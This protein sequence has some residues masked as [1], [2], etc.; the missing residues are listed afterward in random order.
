MG[1]K[2]WNEE[3]ALATSSST[4]DWFPACEC[5]SAGLGYLLMTCWLG[6]AI[7]KNALRGIFLTACYEYATTGQVPNGFTME[8]I[9]RVWR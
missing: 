8:H 5:A 7:L 1:V 2:S 4:P 3:T 9:V 6:L